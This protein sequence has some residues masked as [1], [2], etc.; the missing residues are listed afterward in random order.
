MAPPIPYD[1]FMSG[2]EQSQHYM[3]T[4]R[5]SDIFLS[6]KVRHNFCPDALWRN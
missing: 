1:D 5:H 6:I 4:W 3:G 2:K